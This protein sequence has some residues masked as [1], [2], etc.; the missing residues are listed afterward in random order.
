MEGGGYAGPRGTRWGHENV[1]M[2]IGGGRDAPSGD[3][4]NREYALLDQQGVPT[5]KAQGEA[6]MNRLNASGGRGPTMLQKENAKQDVAEAA[7]KLRDA[8]MGEDR[9]VGLD[10]DGIV[11]LYDQSPDDFGLMHGAIAEYRAAK[12]KWDTLSGQAFQEA[13]V[14]DGTGGGL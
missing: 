3:L 8:V 10:P 14:W 9:F 4:T 1:E 7:G 6:Y 2:P 13:E 5:A 11:D 12:D